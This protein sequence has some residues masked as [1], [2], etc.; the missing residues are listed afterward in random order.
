M[1]DMTV[2]QTIL[3]QL[4]GRRFIVMTGAKN[5]IGSH[6]HLSFRIGRNCHAITHVKITLT[7]WDLYD[8]TFHRL[9]GTDLKLVTEY[10]GVYADDLQRLFTTA[11]GLDTHL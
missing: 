2:A 10:D 6:D 4:G 3:E 1:S 11:T 9:R 5:F 8:M 7:P